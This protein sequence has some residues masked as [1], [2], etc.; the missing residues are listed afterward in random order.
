MRTLVAAALLLLAV[1][2]TSESPPRTPVP[3]PTAKPTTEPTVGSGIKVGGMA[4]VVAGQLRQVAD[5]N[6]PGDRAFESA[7]FAEGR[8]LRP[9]GESQRVLVVGGPTNPN[10]DVYW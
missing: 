8:V 4:V 1:G 6:R 7:A 3:E 5:P 9:L 2:C 10:G